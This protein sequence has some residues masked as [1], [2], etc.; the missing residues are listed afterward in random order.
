MSLNSLINYIS[1][2]QVTSELIKRIN[3]NNELNIKTIWISDI[4]NNQ[5]D[6][7]FKT[8]NSKFIKNFVGNNAYISKSRF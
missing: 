4:N 1:D 2:S 5:A 7:N 6:A 8:I 3:I